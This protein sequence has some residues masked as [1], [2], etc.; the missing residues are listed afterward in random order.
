MAGPK[1]RGNRFTGTATGIARTVVNSTKALASGTPHEA[2]DDVREVLRKADARLNR[3]CEKT[4]PPAEITNAEES[5]AGG[6]P[7]VSPPGGSDGK[8]GSDA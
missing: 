4:R 2:L 7:D 8:S 1:S 6:G 3:I 5:D